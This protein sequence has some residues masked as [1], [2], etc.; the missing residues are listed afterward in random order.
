MDSESWGAWGESPTY[1]DCRENPDAEE[2]ADQLDDCLRAFKDLLHEMMKAD[3]ADEL[4]TAL[5]QLAV[6]LGD[7]AHKHYC[8]VHENLKFNLVK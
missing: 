8:L 3:N 7:E 5:E 1:D 2:L 6:E 4:E